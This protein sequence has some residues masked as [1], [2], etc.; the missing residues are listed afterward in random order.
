MG[1]WL[2]PGGYGLIP[3]GVRP[4]GR[5]TGGDGTWVETPG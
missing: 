5:V 1:E 3:A 4:S 2:C